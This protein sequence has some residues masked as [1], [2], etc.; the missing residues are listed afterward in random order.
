[1]D[2]LKFTTLSLVILNGGCVVY[3]FSAGH[4]LTAVIHTGLGMVL[5]SAIESKL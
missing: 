2:W 5:L 1:M 4:Y 3:G